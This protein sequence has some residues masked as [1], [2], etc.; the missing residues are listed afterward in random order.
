MNIPHLPP[1]R[2]A[3]KVVNRVD[4]SVEVLCEFDIAPTLGMMME[5]AAQGSSAFSD[6]KISVAFLASAKD[7]RLLSSPKKTALLVSIESLTSFSNIKEYKFAFF[8]EDRK[9]SEGIITLYIPH[10]TP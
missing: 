2:Y 7:I 3:K 10:S 5:A 6:G 9:I 4:R 1:I 8:E